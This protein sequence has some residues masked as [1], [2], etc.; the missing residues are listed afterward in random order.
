MNAAVEIQHSIGEARSLVRAA[1]D[2]WAAGNAQRIGEAPALLSSAVE[3][4][5]RADELLLSASPDVRR[6]AR[7]HAAALANEVAELAQLVD[8]SAAFYRGMAARVQGAGASY[9]SCGLATVL[10]E[11]SG[12][13][14][15]EV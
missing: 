7:M 8:S 2:A 1:G 5:R 3:I 4:V 10:P 14:H 15:I 9:D 11:S 6:H 13:P 12:S